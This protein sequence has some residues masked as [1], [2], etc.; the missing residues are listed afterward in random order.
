VKLSIPL[1]ENLSLQIADH[2]TGAEDFPTGRLPKGLLLF[3]GSQGL[4]EEGVGF[5]VPI[6][7]RGIETIFPGG[8]ELTWQQAGPVW[9]VTAA[10]EMNLVERLARSDGGS[11]DSKSLN[12]ARNSLAALHRRSPRWRGPLTVT[13]TALRRTFGWV[14]IF[15]ET[16]S[17]TKLKVTYAVN[18]DEGRIAVAID[19][20]ALANVTELTDRTAPTNRTALTREEVTEVV[21]M[22]EQGARHFDRYRDSDGT[23]LEGSD[24][25]TW[26]EVT[27]AKASFA[28][29]AHRVAFSLEHVDGARL[30][31]GR[32]L[33]GSRLAWSGFGY[34]FPPT[35]ERF[36]YDLRVE[37]IP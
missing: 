34:S 35:Q 7:K 13:S 16:E 6:L 31:R 11:L 2:A 14:T 3:H 28:S 1:F 23:T 32:E 18:G 37:R 5:G 27:A 15:E 21:M 36:G 19:G 17:S 24:I 4:A 25:G 8:M 10:F 29:S 30:H 12:A 20:T 26:D 9:G 22:N 33:V